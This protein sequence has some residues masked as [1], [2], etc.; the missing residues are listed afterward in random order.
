LCR[1]KPRTRKVPSGIVAEV[2]LRPDVPLSPLGSGHAFNLGSA[3]CIE[4]VHECYAELDLGG[5]AIRVA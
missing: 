2:R 3:E 5:L 1:A 4:A